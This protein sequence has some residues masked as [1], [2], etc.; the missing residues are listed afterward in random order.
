MRKKLF[1]L[2]ILAFLYFGRSISYASDFS[3]DQTIIYNCGFSETCLVS[4]SISIT[5]NTSE[6]FASEYTLNTGLKDVSKVTALNQKSNALSTQVDVLNN[7]SVIKIFFDRPILGKGNVTNLTINYETKE[8]IKYTGEIWEI[9][10]PKITK[11][12]EVNNIKITVSVPNN[13]GPLMYTVPRPNKEETENNRFVYSFNGADIPE[14]INIAFG[15]YQLFNFEIYYYLKN[16]NKLLSQTF[17]V[18]FPPNIK[19][20]QKVFVSKLNL[21]P[22]NLKV[23]ENGNYIAQYKLE[24]GEAE[25]VEIYGLIQIFNKE[26]NP[27][28]GGDFKDI[29]Q[30]IVEK[31]TKPKKYWESRKENIIKIANELLKKDGTVSENA[32]RAYSYAVNNLKYSVERTKR[33]YLERFGA[34]KALQNPQDAVCMEFTDLTI[35]LLRAMGIPA[36]EINGYAHS[37]DISKRPLSVF[38]DN[39]KDLLHSWV[40]FFDPEFGWVEIDPTWGQTSGLDFFSKMDVNHIVFVRKD[41]PNYPLPPGVY[42]DETSNKKSVTITFGN[43]NLLKENL[44][45]LDSF[46]SKEKKFSPTYAFL[47]TFLTAPAL[48]MIYLV[49]RGVLGEFKRKG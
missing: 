6:V 8:T 29:P 48:Y 45:P 7:Q 1:L 14:G 22:K 10:I 33:S 31:Y 3:I 12:Q 13:F 5:N 34:V 46:V 18:P 24:P 15:E 28:K 27:A 38:Y 20:I 32:K 30:K 35:A 49:L 26:I 23:D 25:R 36:R 9:S 42:K 17:E 16:D 44:A 40:E 41:D 19:D 37:E 11:T 21:K 2:S 47:I 39:N 43:K 4:N